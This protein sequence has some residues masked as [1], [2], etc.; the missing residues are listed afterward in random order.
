[1]DFNY[2][3]NLDGLLKSIT[4]PS[5][6][7]VN[8]GYNVA[9]RPISAVDSTNNISFATAAHYTG[10]GAL[11][12]L[13]NGAT[14]SFGG[15]VATENYNLRMQPN[16]IHA[17]VGTQPPLLDLVYDYNSCAGNNGNLCAV[18]NNKERPRP[19]QV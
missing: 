8:Y 5:G 16:E 10:S 11:G 14:A 17:A 2:A 19:Q 18:T 6:R 1:M 3:Y 4:Y 9:Q 15:I 12:Y 13:V 7:V